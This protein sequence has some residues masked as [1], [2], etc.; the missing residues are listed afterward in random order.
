MVY[1]RKEINTDFTA[2]KTIHEKTSTFD[3]GAKLTMDFM[4]VELVFDSE[5]FEF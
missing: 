1:D 5:Y 4:G 2:D 3:I